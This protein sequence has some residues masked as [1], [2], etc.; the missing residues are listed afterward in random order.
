MAMSGMDMMMGAVIKSLNLDPEEIKKQ[1]NSFGS[2]ATKFEEG[3]KVILEQQ[4]LILS[5]LEFIEQGLIKENQTNGDS[6]S[7]S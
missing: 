4:K 7:N 1:I 3:M 5:K 6:G 2:I